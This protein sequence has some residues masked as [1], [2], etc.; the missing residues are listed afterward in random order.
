MKRFLGFALVLAWTTGCAFGNRSVTLDYAPG[1]A[2]L[3]HTRHPDVRP[4]VVLVPLGDHRT[5]KQAI[6]TVHNGYGMHTAD[7]IPVNSVSDWVTAALRI[8]L[9]MAGFDVTT[10]TTPGETTIYGDVLK[11]Y[12]EGWT[13]YEA[14]VEFNVRVVRDGKEILSRNYAGQDE[15]KMNWTAEST[16]YAV[17]L[18]AALATAAGNF[19]EDLQRLTP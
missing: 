4:K 3:E 14:A 10:A 13:H 2:S 8:E 7:A 12:C 16:G 9:Q 11:V 5:Q 1:K 17:A 18:T 6:G 15:S 19:A